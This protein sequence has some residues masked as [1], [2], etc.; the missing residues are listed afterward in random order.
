MF[1]PKDFHAFAVRCSVETDD[2]AACRSAISR[3]CYPAFLIAQACVRTRGIRAYP[4]RGEYWGSHKRIIKAVGEIRRPGAA[5]MEEELGKLKH[6]RVKADYRVGYAEA[7]LQMADAL[8]GAAR[9]IAWIDAL[10]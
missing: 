1:D 2:E 7:N 9:I 5:Y 3:A 6:L 4:G 10:P 8:Q